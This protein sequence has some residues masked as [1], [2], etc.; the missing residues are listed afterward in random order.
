MSIRSV[1][2]TINALLSYIDQTTHQTNV[3]I[4]LMECI[5]S[6]NHIYFDGDPMVPT[7]TDVDFLIT[8][9]ILM[10]RYILYVSKDKKLPISLVGILALTTSLKMLNDEVIFNLHIL[11]FCYIN[12][13]CC[14]L[15]SNMQSFNKYE[16]NFLE[17]VQW[18]INVTREEMNRVKSA[19]LTQIRHLE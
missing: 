9:Y 12:Y 17:T 5:A 4:Y 19:I 13:E 18:N 7:L 16:K 3:G 11:Q 1:A 2:C 10:K 6:L 15:I 14:D 8:T